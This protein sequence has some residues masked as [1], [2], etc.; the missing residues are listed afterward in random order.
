MTSPPGSYLARHLGRRLLPLVALTAAVVALGAPCAYLVFGLRTLEREAASTARN[1]AALVEEENRYNLR[2]WKYNAPKLLDHLRRFRTRPK[3]HR[4]EI[5]DQSGRPVTEDGSRPAASFFDLWAS[6]PLVIQ[7]REVG[8][9]WVALSSGGVYANALVVL[10]LFGLAGAGLASILWWLPLLAVRRAGRTIDDLFTRLESSRDALAA[11]NQGLEQRVDER[12]A[13]LS[14]ALAE[15]QQKEARL[16]AVTGRAVALQEEQRRAIAR[17][18]HDAV[19]QAL[20]AIRIQLQIVRQHASGD[21]WIEKQADR[22][23]ELVDEAIDEVRRAVSSLGPAI[24][25]DVGLAEAVDRCCLDFAE[26]TG[27]DV[28]CELPD[29][30]GHLSPAVEITCYRIVQEALTNAARHA[31]ARRITVRLERRGGLLIL[32]VTDDG[33]GLPPGSARVGAGTGLCGIE[34]RIMLLGGSLEI[35]SETGRGTCLRTELPAGYKSPT[36][37]SMG[38][39]GEPER[40]KT[41]GPA[42]QE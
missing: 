22:T 3:V 37:P 4:V 16:R 7:A 26:H 2:L 30:P 36:G 40:T 31:G 29:D 13:Q 21:T 11:L 38:D 5:V 12:S 1:V 41:D 9:A 19:G 34:E 17:D 6:A 32:E 18:L 28:A 23:L 14:S 42:K 27:L 35:E 25:D 24:L 10:L 39:A 33:R 20:T 8:H 15:L